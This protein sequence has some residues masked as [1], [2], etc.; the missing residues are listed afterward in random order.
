[1]ETRLDQLLKSNYCLQGDYTR[2]TSH[3]R[4]WAY[5]YRDT[6]NVTMVIAH[7]PWYK[8]KYNNIVMAFHVTYKIQS[9][10]QQIVE[11]S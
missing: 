11:I 9:N 10:C 2:I 5:H 1:M 8:V 3:G 4:L 7:V 6:S